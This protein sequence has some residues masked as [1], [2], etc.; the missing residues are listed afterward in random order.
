VRAGFGIP[1]RDP[2]VGADNGTTKEV[3]M[4]RSA[5]TFA[6]AGLL[7]GKQ[8]PGADHQGIAGAGQGHRRRVNDNQGGADVA[9]QFPHAFF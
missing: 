1:A 8:R 3:A 6:A 9:L 4:I 5:M 2:H 7:A